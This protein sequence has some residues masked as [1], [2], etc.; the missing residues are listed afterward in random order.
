[1]TRFLRIVV[2][3]LCLGAISARSPA[4]ALGLS[5]SG[6]H[7]VDEGGQPIRLLGVSRSG[8]EYACAEGYGFFD[9]PTGARSIRA[10]KRWGINAVRLPLNPDCW[11]GI[12]G[13]KPALGGAAYINAIDGF[14]ARMNQA[15]LYVVIDEHVAAPAGRKA[16][17][18]IPM[19]DA[20]SSP[21]FWSSVAS[22]FA[23]TTRSS[24]T[25]T[26]SPTTSAGTAGFRAAMF[27]P[28]DGSA[29]AI[30]PTGRRGCS[31]WSTRCA[32]PAPAT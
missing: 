11:L 10:M 23:S 15:G 21:A 26:T 13:V 30:P 8:S 22:H 9:G 29:S 32:P 14:I 17:G 4:A 18:I 16:L 1:M 27:P 6:N 25:F 3:A 2:L 7:L 31:N 19:T 28:G 12:D 24:S 5:V 20:D